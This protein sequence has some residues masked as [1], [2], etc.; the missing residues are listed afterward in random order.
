M[1]RG[2]GLS[3]DE[4][5]R[6]LER[7]KTRR[8]PRQLLE[9]FSERMR[10]MGAGEGDGG[11]GGGSGDRKPDPLLMFC[12]TCAS[13]GPEGTARGFFAS[14]P[15]QI[16]M[17]ANRLRDESEIEETLVHEL[18][19]AVDYCTRDIDLTKCEDLACSEVR[20]AREAE[21]SESTYLKAFPI[22]DIARSYLHRRCTR[23]HATSATGA[24]FPQRAESCI[25]AAFERCFN[26][27]VPFDRK[28]DAD[29]GGNAT[30][31]G[32]ADR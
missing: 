5:A 8:R 22:P 30:V 17:C 32:K 10:E 18:I 26:D 12:M 20:A 2:N 21:C 19:H 24:M 15:E 1:S 28:M 6:F 9:Y 29:D 13:K 23:Q 16:V 25:E 7:A 14:P 27:F 4:C 3:V 11:K 31:D